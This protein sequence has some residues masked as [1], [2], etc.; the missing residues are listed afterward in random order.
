M[1]LS[2]G[3]AVSPPTSGPWTSAEASVTSTLLV[4]IAVMQIETVA[5]AIA[6]VSAIASAASAYTNRQ[7]VDRAHQ[8][9][10]WPAMSR[11][12]DPDGRDVLLVRLHNDGAGTAYDVRG[13]S[14]GGRDR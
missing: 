14:H 3:T 9:F 10:V 11:S 7:A 5:V 13:F 1:L 2:G 6:A 12:R 4:S 8:A